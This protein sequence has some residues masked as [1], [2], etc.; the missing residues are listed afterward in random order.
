LTVARALT[1]SYG[2]G[3]QSIAIAILVV[4]GRLPR[5]E[6]IVMADTSREATETWEY[7]A[8]HVR[9]LLATAGL[10]VEIIPHTLAKVD[11]YTRDGRTLLPA[12]TATG[13]LRSFCSNEWKA[14]VVRRYLRQQGYGPKHPVCTW[15]G[16]SLDEI[17]RLK[18]G[19]KKWQ[20]HA[21]P[22]VFDVPM[23]RSDCRALILGHGL[24]EP[25]KSSCW[26]CPHRGNAQW[27]RLKEHYPGDWAQAVALDEEIRERDG[28]H[29]LYLHRSREPLAQADLTA[30]SRPLSPLFGEVSNC[31][32]GY[33]M[34]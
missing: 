29:A 32:S 21:W 24:P 25:P 22:L 3:T 19:P 16:M 17:G 14:F 23:R 31:D 1:W 8:A 13:Q 28:E 30:P 26:M 10:E 4:E 2:G 5:P 12:W 15:L 11:I 18:P 6:R 34:A 33:C 20:T 9:P 27:A 7:T